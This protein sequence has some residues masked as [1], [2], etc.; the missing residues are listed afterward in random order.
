MIKCD[1]I[2]D[3]VAIVPCI[4][5]SVSG[6]VV[7]HGQVA[8]FISQRNVDVLVGGGVSGVGVVYLGSTRVPV[9]NI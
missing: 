5:S 9:S 1:V 6:V 4:Q 8:I 3:L 2:K 7:K